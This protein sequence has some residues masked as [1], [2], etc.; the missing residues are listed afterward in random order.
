[1]EL[2][3]A[4]DGNRP[5]ANVTAAEPTRMGRQR[6]NPMP[7]ERFKETGCRKPSY[8]VMRE[9]R[10]M[11]IIAARR[12]DPAAYRRACVALLIFLAGMYAPIESGSRVTQDP[13]RTLRV[14]HGLFRSRPASTASA[15]TF[16]WLNSE[17]YAAIARRIETG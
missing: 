13:S 7:A 3:H 8:G 11:R 17:P 6:G 10:T 16:S 2:V 14:C 5:F 12:E 4:K 1:M 9:L 15:Q